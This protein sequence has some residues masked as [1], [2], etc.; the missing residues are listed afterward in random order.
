MLGCVTERARKESEARMVAY[1]S[2]NELVACNKV[3]KVVGEMNH[4]GVLRYTF[5]I[6]F[7][8]M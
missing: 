1:F 5:Q 6:M 3:E 2:I 4:A 8:A 7:T